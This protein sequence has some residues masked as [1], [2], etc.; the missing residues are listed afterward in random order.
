MSGRL[1]LLDKYMRSTTTTRAT[2]LHIG[3][4]IHRC[5][6]RRGT[7]SKMDGG[8]GLWRNYRMPKDGTR[9]RDTISDPACQDEQRARFTACYW[10]LVCLQ[11]PPLYPLLHDCQR[12]YPRHGPVTHTIRT[13]RSHRPILDAL[14]PLG[15][16][17]PSCKSSELTKTIGQLAS[18]TSEPPFVI[19]LDVARTRPHRSSCR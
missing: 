6:A 8:R 5:P 10:Y 19:N 12:T 16:W 7:G 17:S 3:Q 13:S 9:L 4:C 14:G 15:P 1:L 11:N 2:S 18:P